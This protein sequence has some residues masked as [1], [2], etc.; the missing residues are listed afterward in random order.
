ML[1]TTF[2]VTMLKG[3][4]KRNVIPPEAIADIDCRML[5]ATTPRRSCAGCAG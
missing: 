1:R 2:A 5:P 4:E 3:S